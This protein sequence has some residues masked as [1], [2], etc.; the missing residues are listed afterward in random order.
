[1]LDILEFLKLVAETQ[2]MVSSIARGVVSLSLSL[3]RSFRRCSK[4]VSR[5]SA[6]FIREKKTY[7]HDHRNPERAHEYIYNMIDL[8]IIEKDW[9]DPSKALYRRDKVQLVDRWY[10]QR[11]IVQAH[12]HV[13]TIVNYVWLI[14]HEM[15]KK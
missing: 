1:M 4:I 14:C 3:V 15:K 11:T 7:S 6:S 5:L 8:K 12:A 9:N 2:Q 13:D 10:S